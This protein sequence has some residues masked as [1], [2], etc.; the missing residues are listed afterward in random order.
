ML[1]PP[2]WENLFLHTCLSFIQPSENVLIIGTMRMCACVNN[3]RKSSNS[4][5]FCVIMT[6]Y[7]SSLLGKKCN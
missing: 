6:L 1:L 2:F 4:K 5:C 3:Y 7:A